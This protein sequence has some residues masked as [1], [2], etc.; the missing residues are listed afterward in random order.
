MLYN[1]PKPIITNMETK[2]KA[3]AERGATREEELDDLLFV[4]ESKLKAHETD[5]ATS[6]LALEGLILSYAQVLGIVK[7]GAKGT[8][9]IK[10]RLHA[11]A[12]K[13]ATY[14]EQCG[15]DRKKFAGL[16][17]AA[18]EKIGAGI[19]LAKVLE[20]VREQL[21]EQSAEGTLYTSPPAQYQ[22]AVVQKAGETE[23]QDELLARFTKL[24]DS[25]E[26]DLTADESGPG[27]LTL[28]ACALYYGQIHDLHLRIELNQTLQNRFDIVTRRLESYASDQGMNKTKFIVLGKEVGAKIGGGAT[29][30]ADIKRHVDRELEKELEVSRA[31]V[32]AASAPVGEDE[33]QKEIEIEPGHTRATI[34]RALERRNSATEN[35]VL[36]NL[37][38]LYEIKDTNEAKI[39]RI[40][41]LQE[42]MKA[43]SSTSTEN[44]RR[45][46]Q[47]AKDEF[48]AKAREER[49]KELETLEKMELGGITDEDV[50]AIKEAEAKKQ[51]EEAPAV[52]KAVKST[53]PPIVGQ[54]PKPQ[55]APKRRRGWG[56]R[57]ARAAAFLG[58]LFLTDS[59]S[60]EPKSVS[61]VKPAPI[62]SGTLQSKPAK[63][64]VVR[65]PIT[66]AE[67]PCEVIGKGDSLWRAAR[68]LVPHGQDT[69]F[70]LAW[71]DPRSVVMIDGKNVPLYRVSVTHP[72]DTVT[73][74]PDGNGRTGYFLYTA[75]SN[76]APDLD[77]P[78]EITK[79][80]VGR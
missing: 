64:E 75:E 38:A 32:A 54:A 55:P 65:E 58:A 47:A 23:T 20:Y 10:T 59:A 15:V 52:A 29:P 68:R 13:L 48:V 56:G 49:I 63:P 16:S 3:T 50:K 45:I 7:A 69:E 35:S 2:G 79:A 24:L 14:S 46:L 62:A 66:P 21:T 73:Y 67:Y 28:S 76:I 1:T 78:D 37:D 43:S 53:P 80:D 57:L 22:E 25:I 72:G 61:P 27:A 71:E 77:V 40:A 70:S 74:C 41:E 17:K 6:G 60:R 34:A 31:E 51:A 11:A 33:G 4:I 36:I 26:E 9:E 42:T 44:I 30:M 39:A 8:G 12:V 18:S 5:P 19:D